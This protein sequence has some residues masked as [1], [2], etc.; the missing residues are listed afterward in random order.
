VVGR[1]TGCSYEVG[2][3]FVKVYTPIWATIVLASL[4]M[5]NQSMFTSGAFTAFPE[6]VMLR[7]G[8]DDYTHVSYVVNQLRFQPPQKLPVYLLGG[9]LVREYIVSEDSFGSLVRRDAG[10]DVQV[11]DLGSVN[12]NFA[13]SLAIVDNLPPGPGVVVITVYPN[14]FRFSPKEIAQQLQGHHLW[15]ESPTLRRFVMSDPQRDIPP[16]WLPGL[17]PGVMEYF[18]DYLD[19]HEATLAAGGQPNVQHLLHRVW[20]D[21][22]WSVETQARFLKKWRGWRE[23]DFYRYQAYNSRLL[24]TLVKRARQRGFEVVLLEGSENP[25][26]VGHALDGLKSL[27]KPAMARIAV[28]NGVPY[29][30]LQ[31]HL[32]L[33]NEDFRDLYHLVEPGRVVWQAAMAKALRP[34]VEQAAAQSADGQY[35][36]TAATAGGG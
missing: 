35:A 19:R 8:G 7:N 16:A 26:T 31:Q 3:D 12:Q 5:G 30:D 15:L 21:K 14:R 29:I 23:A 28:E 34:A 25:Y 18:V 33:T 17:L 13:E 6:Q 4:L 10:A 36:G 9:S 32:S 27:Y 20:A 22:L 11:V 24:D 2:R 1:F